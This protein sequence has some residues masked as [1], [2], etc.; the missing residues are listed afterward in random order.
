MKKQTFAVIGL[1]RFGSAMAR[2]LTELGQ[3]VIGIDA[4]PERVQRHADLIRSALELD[5]NDER[6]LR[7]AGVQDVDVAVISIGE[8]IEAS[9]L[10]VMLVKDLGVPRVIAKAVT[11]LH[12]RI[13]ERIGVDRVIFPER[14]MAIRVAH[15]LVVANVLDYIE[16][17]RDFSIIELPAPG[18]FTG[19]SLKELQLRNRFGL[20]L[21]A[22]KRK[23]EGGG[24]EVTNVAPNA[25][26]RILAGDILALLGPNERLAQLD[27]V[28]KLG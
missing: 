27:K 19:K 22:I 26:D 1:G 17:S 4:D 14:E 9:L 13:L 6:A 16:L 10:A 8:N 2:T 15:S 7:T 5:A 23:P 24:P 20:T 25:D 18:E 3:D 11:T 12:G 28:L 21:I